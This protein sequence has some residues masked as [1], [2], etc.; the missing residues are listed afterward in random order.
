MRARLLEQL[1]RLLVLRVELV[2]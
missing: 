2:D 1:D